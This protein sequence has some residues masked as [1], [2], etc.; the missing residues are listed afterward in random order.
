MIAT[1]CKPVR[2]QHAFDVH[3]FKK[4]E[5]TQRWHLRMARVGYTRVLATT[6][7]VL[8][9][10]LALEDMGFQMQVSGQSIPGNPAD[11]HPAEWHED[12][13]T[14]GVMLT[15]SRSLVSH[16]LHSSAH[17]SASLPGMFALLISTDTA[18][19]KACL[20]K[21]SRLWGALQGLEAAMLADRSLQAFHTALV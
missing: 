5:K 8:Q 4:V 14:A 13:Y 10:P 7:S 21:L 1:V 17:F 9:D 20:Q 3:D 11:S 19:R 2:Q 12:I 15:L 18:E 6:W 16:M